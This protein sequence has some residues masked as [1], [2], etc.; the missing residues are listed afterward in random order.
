MMKKKW[1][2]IPAMAGVL[3]IGGVAMAD[4]SAPSVKKQAEK[5]I[6]LQERNKWLLK[7]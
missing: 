6:S 7:R 4:D 2:L 3:A 1:M 5:L